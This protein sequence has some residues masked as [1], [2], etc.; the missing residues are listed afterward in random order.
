MLSFR[1]L[2]IYAGSISNRTTTKYRK[3]TATD[4]KKRYDGDIIDDPKDSFLLSSFPRT[5]ILDYLQYSKI[6]AS[7]PKIISGHHNNIIEPLD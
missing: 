2:H 7:G 4:R 5:N 3:A 6:Y 1:L